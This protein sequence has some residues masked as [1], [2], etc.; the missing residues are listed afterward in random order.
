M[1]GQIGNCILIYVTRVSFI[2][3]GL[4]TR[5]KYMR[6][7]SEFMTASPKK[8]ESKYS[9]DGLFWLTIDS[10]HT[11]HVRS[12]RH[13]F[14]PFTSPVFLPVLITSCKLVFETNV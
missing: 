11:L 9:E 2:V 10:L 6:D 3:H 1:H 7:G 13:L 12:F 5:V 4:I 14:S 8:P